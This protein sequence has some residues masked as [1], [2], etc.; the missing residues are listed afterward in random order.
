MTLHDDDAVLGPPFS[1]DLL[2]DLHAGVLPDAVS[3]KL[4]PLVRQDPEAV[5]V[6]DA[7]DAVSARLAEAG[8]D[9][10]VETP[11][12]HDVAARINSALGLNVSAPRS[13]VVPLADATAKRR[14]MAW[15]GVAAAS[16]AAAVAVVFALTGVDRS[17]STGPEAVASATTTAPDVAAA[18]VELS[19]ELDRGQLLALV[20]DTES[21]ADGVGALA[22]PEVRSACLSAVGVGAT[23]P[24]LGMRAVRFQDTDA[25]L[26][27][28][29]GPTPPTLLA[30]VVG[31]G[32][33][34]THPDLIDSTEIG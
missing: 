28:V 25:V 3:D 26:L 31:T 32:C 7:L 23:R 16:M 5:A 15:L 14:R 20:G 24:V 22:R 13:D 21:A 10:S 19:G 17:G 33:D 9:H 1:T 6:L 4:W 11:I 2:A 8:R 12:P 18:R 27:L 29:A 30:L 34:A